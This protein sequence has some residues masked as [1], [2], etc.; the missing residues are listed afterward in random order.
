MAAILALFHKYFD[1][2]SESVV[3][4]FYALVSLGMGG[5][6]EVV[7]RAQKLADRA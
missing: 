5:A 2:V 1:H 3:E 4:S 7:V 6:D